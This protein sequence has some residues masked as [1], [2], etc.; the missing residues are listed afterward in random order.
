MSDVVVTVPKNFT[1]DYDGLRPGRN[2]AGPV[3]VHT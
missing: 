1:M 2:S 3:G